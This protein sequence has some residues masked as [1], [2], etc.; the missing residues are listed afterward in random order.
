MSIL[1]TLRTHFVGSGLQLRA[2]NVPAALSL[3]LQLVLLVQYVAAYNVWSFKTW[4]V[5][6]SVDSRPSKW[7]IGTVSKT[8]IW[9]PL[10]GERLTENLEHVVCSIKLRVL[11]PMKRVEERLELCYQ[12]AL[13]D[14]T[15]RHGNVRL[16]VTGDTEGFPTAVTNKRSSLVIANHR[17]VMDYS[18]INYL[19]QGEERVA[20]RQNFWRLFE[21]KETD[22]MLGLKFVTWGR[23]CNMP[24]LRLLSSILAGD[25]NCAV[26]AARLQE[27][28]EDRGNQIL[29][30]FPE[31]NVLTPELRLVQRKLAKDNY[32]PMLNNVLYPRFKNFKAAIRCLSHVRGV[33]IARRGRRLRNAVTKADSMVCKIRHPGSRISDTQIAQVSMFLGRVEDDEALA[34]NKKKLKPTQRALLS[35]DPFVW[36][37]TIVY[38]RAKIS[39]GKDH[40]HLHEQEQKRLEDGAHYQLEQV[41]PSFLQMASSSFQDSPLLI[42]IHTCKHPMSKLLALSDRKLEKWLER[43]WMQ[44]DEMID[45]IQK[46]VKIS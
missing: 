44:K 34:K 40:A 42:R 31:V 1:D 36:D 16:L 33:G 19:A 23:V 45:S 11:P 2:D 17:S 39:K 20:A 22:T 12:V 4:I 10:V 14:L 9:I 37:L 7:A 41:T 3:V 28:L 15:F 24:S 35:V 5:E 8:L 38:Y 29:A 25:E 6:Q 32:L 18:L 13:A 46:N 26:D 30:V 43:R 27:F 21:S